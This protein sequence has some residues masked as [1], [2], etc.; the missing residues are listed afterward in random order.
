MYYFWEFSSSSRQHLLKFPLFSLPVCL[1]MYW[2]YENVF[3]GSPFS[4]RYLLLINS[5][6][7]LIRITYLIISCNC[8]PACC[9]PANAMYILRISF[10]PW[11]KNNPIFFKSVISKSFVPCEIKII[12][13]SL[14]QCQMIALVSLYQIYYLSSK[15]CNTYREL[16]NN[17]LCMHCRPMM[18]DKNI[19]ILLIKG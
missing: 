10:V 1:K 5:S 12:L 15:A 6:L 13:F 17:V 2:D 3:S 9:I 14:H 16:D 18:K 19:Y 8:F 4:E 11:N 7:F